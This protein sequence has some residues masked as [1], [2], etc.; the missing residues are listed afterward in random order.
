[1]SVGV[2]T[3]EGVG[4]GVSYVDVITGVGVGVN[5]EGQ[6]MNASRC[7][8][9]CV[10]G[11]HT[12]HTHTS[13]RPDSMKGLLFFSRNPAFDFSSSSMQTLVCHHHDMH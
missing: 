9:V 6:G 2:G 10:R 4:L 7:V 1:M 8:G 3:S 5:E 13:H 12:P 11:Q